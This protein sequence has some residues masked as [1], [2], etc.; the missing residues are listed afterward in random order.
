MPLER[1]IGPMDMNEDGG[2]SADALLGPFAS[3]F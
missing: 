3:Q 2:R 1:V